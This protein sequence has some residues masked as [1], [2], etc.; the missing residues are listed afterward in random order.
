[1]FQCNFCNLKFAEIIGYNRHLNLH[2]NVLNC[3]FFCLHSN[4]GM[5]FRKYSN[6]KAHIYRYHGQKG[7]VKFTLI[8][9]S[10]PD[11]KFSEIEKRK[12]MAHMIQHIRRGNTF[13]C[14]FETCKNNST[15]FNTKSKFCVHVYRYHQISTNKYCS[16]KGHKNDSVPENISVISAFCNDQL[17]S[18]HLQ[19]T[20]DLKTCYLR[21][22]SMIY[23]NLQSKYF[24][25]DSVLQ[26][27]IDGL[28]NCTE[29]SKSLL[30][31]KLQNVNLPVNIIQSIVDSDFFCNL[32]SKECGILRTPHVRKIY[33]KNNFHYIE[34]IPIKLGRNANHKM[35]HYYYIPIIK[36]LE[37]LLENENVNNYCNS[38]NGFETNNKASDIGINMLAKNKSFFQK[39]NSLK[40]MLYQDAFEVCNPL[41]SSK[42]KHKMIGVYMIIKNMPHFFRSKTDQIQ[43]VLLCYE[44]NVKSFGFAKIF[45]RVLSDIKV[46][47]KGTYINSILYYG[48]IFSVLGDNLGSHQI[49]GFVENFATS[50]YFCR[51]CLISRYDFNNG[52]YMPMEPRTSTNY[53]NAID[54]LKSNPKLEHYFGIKNNSCLNDLTYFNVCDPGL[55]PCLAHDI[56]EGIIQFDLS[57][58]INY[59]NKE[60]WFSLDELNFKLKSVKLLYDSE[61]KKPVTIKKIKFYVARQVRI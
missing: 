6:F 50:E 5:Q 3:T 48:S 7:E 14:P 37:L 44:S 55:P 46:L 53:N 27:V 35:C 16:K 39:P 29:L 1:M 18:T 21:S 28:L 26:T 8:Y 43:L 11:C 17:V 20:D 47:E 4:C 61:Y 25:P 19:S 12:F 56:Y 10:V 41:G 45:E 9:C 42:I 24:L 15:V 52:N 22:I 58:M 51:Y 38:L 59:L 23:L 54:V 2:K 60:Q 34:P 40:I 31:K 33:Y 49:G 13:T 57:L 36:T 32:H 30:I